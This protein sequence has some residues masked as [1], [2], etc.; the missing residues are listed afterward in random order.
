M[1]LLEGYV[2]RRHIVVIDG[3]L[4][5]SV[6]RRVGVWAALVQRLLGHYTL[7]I[8]GRAISEVTTIVC[9]NLKIGWRATVDAIRLIVFWTKRLTFHNVVHGNKARVCLL[10]ETT[11]EFEGASAWRH[12]RQD[13]TSSILILANIC[14]LACFPCDLIEQLLT[15]NYN[16]RLRDLLDQLCFLLLP[17][18][19]L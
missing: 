8:L 1:D 15:R 2:S 17:L 12:P 4:L 6:H 11:I 13:V 10:V 16:W 7:T 18:L 3:V 9:P 14:I 19:E 5:E